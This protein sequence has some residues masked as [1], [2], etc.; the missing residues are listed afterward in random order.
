[1][2][3]MAAPLRFM[4]DLQIHYTIWMEFAAEGLSKFQTDVRSGK[5]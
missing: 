1:M 4:Q 3:I 5:K 2:E